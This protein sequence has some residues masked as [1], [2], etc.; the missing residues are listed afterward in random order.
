MILCLFLSIVNYNRSVLLIRVYA[1]SAPSIVS[2]LPSTCQYVLLSQ[3]ILIFCRSKICYYFILSL[4]TY[5]K[6]P[7]FSRTSLESSVCSARPNFSWLL[8]CSIVCPS[9]LST[10]QTVCVFL[11]FNLFHCIFITASN[12]LPI[13]PHAQRQTS[14]NTNIYSHWRRCLKRSQSTLQINIFD[15]LD[16]S[17]KTFSKM[18][19]VKTKSFI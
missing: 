15:A 18:D 16:A 17:S 14:K 3:W 13:P 11:S 12:T 5:R 4:S 6:P 1:S 7:F 19:G 2:P 8:A 9:V 10:L